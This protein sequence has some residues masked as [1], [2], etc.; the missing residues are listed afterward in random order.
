MKRT[1]SNGSEPTI[2]EQVIEDLV[3]R[4][5]VNVP[6]V[7]QPVARWNAKVIELPSPKWPVERQL[8]VAEQAMEL[9]LKAQLNLK[10]RKGGE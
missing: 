4:S 5:A 1:M 2:F 10:N 8:R 7:P 3:R 9:A 6:Y